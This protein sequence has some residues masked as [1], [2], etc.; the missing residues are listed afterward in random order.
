MPPVNAAAWLM[1]NVGCNVPVI[2]TGEPWVSGMVSLPTNRRDS[3]TW[4]RLKGLARQTVAAPKRHGCYWTVT[5]SLM[6]CNCQ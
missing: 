1:S 6:P 4:H 3:F 5:G 2:C